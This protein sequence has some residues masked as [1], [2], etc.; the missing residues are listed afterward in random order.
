MHQGCFHIRSRRWPHHEAP[1]G[2]LIEAHATISFM[3]IRHD[4]LRVQKNDEMLR[5]E[6]ESIHD[7]VF[8]RQPNG[9]ALCN[10][11]LCTN[12]A[13]IHVCEFVWIADL[14]HAARAGDFGH[15]RANHLCSGMKRHQLGLGLRHGADIVSGSSGFLKMQFEL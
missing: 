6:S 8:L 2:C 15:S 14:L 7:Q 12:D 3:H 9:A 4:L 1:E 5:K 13:H 11:K 10:T